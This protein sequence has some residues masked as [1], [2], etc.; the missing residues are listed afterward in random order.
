MA[1]ALHRAGP[2]I[3]ASAATV[4]IRMSILT[5]A[6]LNST[7]GLGPVAAL[8]IGVGLLAMITLL[9]ALLVIFGRWLF[10]PVRPK[11]G[12]AEPTATG[13]WA[14]L[15]ARIAR[16]PRTV[17]ISTALVLGIMSLG[18]FQL[19]ANGLST[20]DTFT[21]KQPSVTGEVALGRHFPA[22]GGQPVT[23]IANAAQAGQVR[24]AFA[25]TPGIS[26]VADPV[27]KHGL[28][29]LS[30]TLEAAPDSRWC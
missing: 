12:S 27:V 3:I 16:R 2:A 29:Q 23:V 11:A 19:N 26:A 22:G 28:V 14:R 9:P 6:E 20:A 18:L 25:G 21:T 10:W 1:L 4:A 8:G 15:G 24:A 5:L 7:S 17:W 30:G 13:L